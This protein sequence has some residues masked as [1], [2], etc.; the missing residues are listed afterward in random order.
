MSSKAGLKKMRAYK[1]KKKRTIDDVE[2]D[3]DL[4]LPPLPPFR[5]EDLWNTSAKVRAL[6]DRDLTLFS[7]PSVS[8]V[9]IY[10]R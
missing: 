8:A 1:K 6:A 10:I 4:D 5:P 9:P 2:E 7:D 3:G